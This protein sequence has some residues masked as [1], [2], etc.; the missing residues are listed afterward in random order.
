MPRYFFNIYDGVDELDLTGTELE[1]WTEA[2]LE[3][4]R[5]AGVIIRDDAKRLAL[6][7]DWR[8]EVTDDVGLVLFRLDFSILSS[9]AVPNGK[10]T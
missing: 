3:A 4:V 8:L 5:F 1:D 6:G 7:E 9:A 10:P 2:R